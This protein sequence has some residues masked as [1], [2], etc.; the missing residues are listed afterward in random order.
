M[1]RYEN[2]VS[3]PDYILAQE[4]EIDPEYASLIVPTMVICKNFIDI[5][6]A[7]ALW[8]PGCLLYTSLRPKKQKS[9]P[10]ATERRLPLSVRYSTG[11]S[12]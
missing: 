4:M 3:K 10:L 7:E 5:F 2:T 11:Q 6:N 12:C 8:V 9:C 1:N